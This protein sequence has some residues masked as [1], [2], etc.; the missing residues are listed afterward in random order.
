MKVLQ[1]TF[2]LG[3]GEVKVVD[4][5]T[6]FR[7]FT[8]VITIHLPYI[9]E[10]DI[11]MLREPAEHMIGEASVLAVKQVRVKGYTKTALV[12]QLHDHEEEE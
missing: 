1:N 11:V 4:R 7:R 9:K 5:L 8:T 2:A 10:G 3:E 6:A 12:L